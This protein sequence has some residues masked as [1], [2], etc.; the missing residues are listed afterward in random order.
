MAGIEFLNVKEL[1]TPLGPYSHVARARGSEHIYVSG[2]VG[3]DPSGKV[4][5]GFDAQCEQAYANI[6]TAL[7]AVGADWRHVASFTSYLVHS[8]DIPGYMTY[9]ARAYPGF[10]PSRIYPA[11]TLLIVDRFVQEPLLVEVTATAVL[12]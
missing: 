8:Q 5:Q 11:H 7:K 9:R 1:G 12:P 3:V 2:M 10:F 4:A 6:A